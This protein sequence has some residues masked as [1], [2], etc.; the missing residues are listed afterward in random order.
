M[1]LQLAQ[2]V[3]AAIVHAAAARE[4]DLKER[5]WAD[6]GESLLAHYCPT[7]PQTKAA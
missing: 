7:L 1:Q 6:L 4:S 5:T 2:D 3:I